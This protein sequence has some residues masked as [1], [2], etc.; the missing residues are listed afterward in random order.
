VHALRQRAAH[1]GAQAAPAAHAPQQQRQARAA[2]H[3]HGQ[4]REGRAPAPRVAREQ[5]AVQVLDPA[6]QGRGLVGA[7]D[8]AVGRIDAHGARLV[9]L[10][11]IDH[12]H[13]RR[14]AAHFLDAGNGLL[15]ALH[16]RGHGQIVGGGRCMPG[17]LQR[18][19]GQPRAAQTQ[20]HGKRAQHQ[21][22]PAVDCLP[23]HACVPS[24][25]S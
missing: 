6:W 7:E 8:G 1:A 13:A 24:Y 16:Q 3:Q 5:R 15:H 20:H 22:E 4:R 25:C 21:A 11:G 23:A 10:E 18:V 14:Q 19:K 17:L 2:E 9:A 12:D